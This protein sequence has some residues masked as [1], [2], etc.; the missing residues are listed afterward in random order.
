ML[1]ENPDE[2]SLIQ[3]QDFTTRFPLELSSRIFSFFPGSKWYS[4]PLTLALV[5]KPWRSIAFSTPELWTYITISIREND[6][7]HDLAHAQG[8][9]EWLS[10]AG[11]LQLS[12]KICYR[13]RRDFFRAPSPILLSH[14]RIVIFD[15]GSMRV[16]S[17]HLLKHLTV[18]ALDQLTMDLVFD[19]RHESPTRDFINL[20][21]RSACP[22][23]QFLI[24]YWD[25]PRY[26]CDTLYGTLP[27][28]FENRC[29]SLPPPSL[30]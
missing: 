1:V 24:R 20:F 7:E 11:Q 28:T 26:Y 19:N 30:R 18:L 14:L 9:A 5:S 2:N 13:G 4:G 23:Q 22:L 3:L 21:S 12:V 27:P 29:T 6:A 16:D 17:L 25:C 15:S 10:H 8:I